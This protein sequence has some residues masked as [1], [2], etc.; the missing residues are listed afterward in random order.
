MCQLIVM[1]ILTNAQEVFAD[2]LDSISGASMENNIGKIIK[3]MAILTALIYGPFGFI[4]AAMAWFG[5]H[6]EGLAM[7]KAKNTGER[8]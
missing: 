1:F 8:K 2:G 3:W 5:E 7:K 4:Q 6:D